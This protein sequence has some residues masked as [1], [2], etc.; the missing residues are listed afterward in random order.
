MSALINCSRIVGLL[1]VLAVAPVVASAEVRVQGLF[2]GKAMFSLDGERFL[3]RDGETG[4]GGLRL[5]RATSQSALVEHN[6]QRRELLL[7]K[8]RFGGLYESRAQPELRIQPDAQGGYFVQGLING[9]SI[10]FVV[11]TGA[12]V[13]TL[14]ETEAERLRLPVSSPESEIAVETASGRV[15]GRRVTLN[16]LRIGALHERRVEA[17]VLPGDRPAVALL[18]MS[19]LS[20][21]NMRNDGSVLILQ[22]R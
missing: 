13:V 6:G 18:G 12:T 3:L 2:N 7:E 5:I 21:L 10:R 15:T 16:D 14:S 4:P 11:D 19:L 9:R 17:V 22:A 8:G 20:R 1:M